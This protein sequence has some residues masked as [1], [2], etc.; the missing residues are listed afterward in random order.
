MVFEA[1][2]LRMNCFTVTWDYHGQRVFSCLFALPAFW[3]QT[4]RNSYP[5]SRGPESGRFGFCALSL[6]DNYRSPI[7]SCRRSLLFTIR[8]RQTPLQCSRGCGLGKRILSRADGQTSALRVSGPRSRAKK[9][10]DGF[11]LVGHAFTH[12]TKGSSRLTFRD[13]NQLTQIY[14]ASSKPRRLQRPAVGSRRSNEPAVVSRHRLAL[15]CAAPSTARL[16]LLSRS[17]PFTT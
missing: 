13:T 2:T 8:A 11:L 10:Q 7:L 12:G 5:R 1:R 9:F 17:F 4:Y 15:S 3:S 14:T 6:L 16:L